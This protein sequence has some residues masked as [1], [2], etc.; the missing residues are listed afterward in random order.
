MTELQTRKG[1]VSMEDKLRWFSNTM[2]FSRGKSDNMMLSLKYGKGFVKSDIFYG[3]DF[4]MQTESMIYDMFKIAPN[5]IERKTYLL[6]LLKE[7]ICI[8]KR[9]LKRSNTL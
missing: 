6:D 3:S 1:I 5:A 4:F 8:I 2:S 7:G 9:S